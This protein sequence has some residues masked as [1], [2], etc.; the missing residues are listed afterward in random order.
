MTLFFSASAGKKLCLL[1]I[2]AAALSL[3]ACAFTDGSPWGRVLATLELSPPS[4]ATLSEVGISSVR[5]IREVDGQAGSADFDPAN[6]PPGY[7]LCHNGHCHSDDGRL[8]DYASI[9]SESG[10]GSQVVSA[11]HLEHTLT[12]Q[13]EVHS[14]LKIN[15]R[16]PLSAV[17]VE[18]DTL[19]LEA[20]LGYQGQMVEVRASVPVRGYRVRAPIDLRIDR[21]SAAEQEL[22]LVLQLPSE[23]FAGLDLDDATL[24]EDGRLRITNTRNRELAQTLSERITAGV[25]LSLSP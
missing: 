24:E 7:S 19:V 6:P 3:P 12:S 8:V 21:E 2:A 15:E 20:T 9:A 13:A 22:P 5:L 16:G 4:G 1:A 25:S 11:V 17:E 10:G 23:L 18:L 14:S